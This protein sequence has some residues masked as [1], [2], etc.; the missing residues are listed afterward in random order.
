VTQQRPEI[1]GGL[2]RD[3]GLGQQ[4]GA[5][6]LGQGVGIDLVVLEPGRGDL[7]AA[8]GMNQMRFQ[9]Q[10]L[11]QIDQPTPAVGG[12]E[13]HRGARWQRAKD[14]H[15]LRRIVGNVAVALGDAGVIQH[16][17][18]RALAVDVHP[19]LDTHQGLLPRAR[20]SPKPRL[21]G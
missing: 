20:R 3:P 16:R 6:Q 11:E 21:S 14:R 13:R 18:L 5:Q 4:V 2:G 19:D 7:L 10:L 1:P 9:F 17:D 8:A 15:Q 12:L